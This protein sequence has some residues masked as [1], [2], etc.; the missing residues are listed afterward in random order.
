MGEER[1]AEK[2]EVE[3]EGKVEVDTE[4]ED[5]TEEVKA[6]EVVVLTVVV[7]RGEKLVN[8]ST[9]AS[10]RRARKER[11]LDIWK[12]RTRR[13][14]RFRDFAEEGRKKVSNAFL[15]VV[16][17]SPSSFLPSTVSLLVTRMGKRERTFKNPRLASGTS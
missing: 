12:L 16:R 14:E 7:I 1:V 8:P 13:P 17:P 5:D 2:R 6:T 9:E 11:V 10:A 4:E 3:V 15:L